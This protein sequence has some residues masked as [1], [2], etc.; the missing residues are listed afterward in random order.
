MQKALHEKALFFCIIYL[1]G[2]RLPIV[3]LFFFFFFFFFFTLAK[4]LERMSCLLLRLRGHRPPACRLSL[5]RIRAEAAERSR[6]SRKA[7]QALERRLGREEAAAPRADDGAGAGGAGDGDGGDGDGGTPHR[8]PPSR[9][10]R[11]EAVQQDVEARLSTWRRKR[12]LAEAGLTEDAAGE[13]DGDDNHRSR[14]RHPPGG[15]SSFFP[16]GYYPEQAAAGGSVGGRGGAFGSPSSDGLG[17]RATAWCRTRAA[18][19]GSS[20][21]GGGKSKAGRCWPSVYN[22][23]VRSCLPGHARGALLRSGG[24]AHGAPS[25]ERRDEEERWEAPWMMG[26]VSRRRTRRRA[27]LPLPEGAGGPGGPGEPVDLVSSEGEDDQDKQQVVADGRVAASEGRKDAAPVVD[28]AADGSARRR[29]G[30]RGD[31]SGGGRSAERGGG[32]ERA[33]GGR[34]PS[35]EREGRRGIQ[36]EEEEEN[37]GLSDLH[38]EIVKFEEYVSLTPS[39][40]GRSACSPVPHAL[41]SGNDVLH[42]SKRVTFALHVPLFC[43][44]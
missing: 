3:C 32:R 22:A 34:E 10:E 12:A 38:H 11:R 39:E 41:C 42:S 40:V 28:G 24:D 43:I 16:N 8:T 19:P 25:E 18:G 2:K 9:A 37:D 4:A 29:R 6:L 26:L 14:R 17:W 33:G 20:L 27:A 23:P 44:E 15:G 5:Q 1:R 35:E 7:N 31:G 21:G 30:H 36:E 13:H